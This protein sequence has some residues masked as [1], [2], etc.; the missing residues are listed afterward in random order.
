MPR[1]RRVRIDDKLPNG[2]DYPPLKRRRYQRRNSKVATMLFPSVYQTAEILRSGVDDAAGAAS[3]PA[4][5]SST[6]DQ[7]AKSVVSDMTAND[8]S[9]DA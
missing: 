5:S 4:D 9:P 8:K 6:R 7:S 2:D 1:R 3:P